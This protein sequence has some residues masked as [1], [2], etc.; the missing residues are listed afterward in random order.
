MDTYAEKVSYTSRDR[1]IRKVVKD[2]WKEV[3]AKF[4][5]QKKWEEGKGPRIPPKDFC[6]A[7]L[8][9]GATYLTYSFC[10]NLSIKTNP[11]CCLMWCYS[12]VMCT[13]LQFIFTYCIKSTGRAHYMRVSKLR[14]LPLWTWFPLWNRTAHLPWR[15]PD[16]IIQF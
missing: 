14:P 4:P 13:P 6:T 9:V 5:G 15:S 8:I 7:S 16:C 3:F 11:N 12:F 1:T 2:V 10:S